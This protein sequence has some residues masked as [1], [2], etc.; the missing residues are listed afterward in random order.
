M[1]DRWDLEVMRMM[2]MKVQ[3]RIRVGNGSG[4]KC[5]HRVHINRRSRGQGTGRVRDRRYSGSRRGRG[6]GDLSGGRHVDWTGD[7]EALLLVRLKHVGESESLA[8]HVAWV[9]LLPRVRS[10]VPLHVG[11]TGEAFAADFTDKGLLSC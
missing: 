11:P 7:P 9:W 1:R 10:T 8:A 4:R 3:V 6:E 2:W 5:A